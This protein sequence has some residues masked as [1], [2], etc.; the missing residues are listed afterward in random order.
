M[1]TSYKENFYELTEQKKAVLLAIQHASPHFFFHRAHTCL[2]HLMYTFDVVMIPPVLPV[3]L[4]RTWL[5]D[6]NSN[7]AMTSFC[8]EQNIASVYTVCRI[9]NLELRISDQSQG[10]ISVGVDVHCHPFLY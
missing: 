3:H 8:I 10:L 4:S 5:V 9:R 1:R 6:A 7:E 2:F